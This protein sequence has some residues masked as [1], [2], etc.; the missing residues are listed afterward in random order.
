MRA[1]FAFCF[2]LESCKTK[3]VRLER[4]SECLVIQ[5]ALLAINKIP[6]IPQCALPPCPIYQTLLFDF[7]RVWIRNYA[8]IRVSVASSF[9]GGAW[10]RG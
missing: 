4:F 8:K 6:N 5:K 10:G 3:R 2:V 9:L 1:V 7:S